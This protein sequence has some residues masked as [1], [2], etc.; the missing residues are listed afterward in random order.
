M[1]AVD[2]V[3]LKHVD[4]KLRRSQMRASYMHACGLLY[5]T[6]P[7]SIRHRRLALVSIVYY[8]SRVIISC[9]SRISS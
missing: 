4:L 6:A 3:D 1:P 7:I 9:S 5:E 2:Y 8:V